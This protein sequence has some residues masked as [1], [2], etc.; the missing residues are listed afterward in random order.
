MY[1]RE[2]RS[3]ENKYILPCVFKVPDI[4]FG[5]YFDILGLFVTLLF[6]SLISSESESNNSGLLNPL[7]NPLEVLYWSELRYLRIKT[8]HK[9]TLKNLDNF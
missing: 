3:I 2:G 6:R 8:L 4:S 5:E 7:L 1:F 9:A